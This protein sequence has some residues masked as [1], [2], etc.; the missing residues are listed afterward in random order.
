[1][2]VLVSIRTSTLYNNSVFLIHKLP[3]LNLHLSLLI[4][5]LKRSKQAKQLVP[6]AGKSDDFDALVV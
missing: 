3:K 4:S 1:M 5:R 6:E 2:H